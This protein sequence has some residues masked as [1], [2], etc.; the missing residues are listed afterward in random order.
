MSAPTRNWLV[1][2]VGSATLKAAVYAVDGDG[3]RAGASHRVTI[4]LGDDADVD[5]ALSTAL[6]GTIGLGNIA[7]SRRRS[8]TGWFTAADALVRSC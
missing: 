4:P 7:G 5:A 6:S 3:E 2:N 8:C 1:M